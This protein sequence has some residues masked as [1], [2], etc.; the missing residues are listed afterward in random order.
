MANPEHLAILKQGVKAWNK[1]RHEN[2]EIRPDF[3]GANLNGANLGGE[4]ILLETFPDLAV[5]ELIR[6]FGVKLFDA[7]LCGTN[8]SGSN[9]LYADL[10]GACLNKANLSK[11]NLRFADLTM[12]N[13]IQA[14]LSEADLS[15]ANLSGAIIGEADLSRAVLRGAFLAGTNLF[16]S[17]LHGVNLS[18]SN[19]T[20]ANFIETDLTGADLSEAN[21]SGANLSLANLSKANLVGAELIGTSLVG[22]NLEN[23]DL[24][25]CRI[26][27]ISA[28]N[29]R[30]NQE[31]IQSNL[32]IT[33]YDEAKL[34]VDDL[35]VAQFLYL[36]LNNK[37]I[38]NVIDT[39][40]KKG[41]LILGRFTEERKAVLDAIRNKLRELGFIPLMFD[42]EKPTQRDFTET[43][44]ILAGMSRFII[45]DITNPKS[46][47]LEL[48]ATM[49]DYMIP[50]VPIIQEGEE[51]FSMFQDLTQKYGEWV[52][53]PLE[54]DTTQG[55]LDVFD[56]AV[57]EPANDKAAQLELK[58]AEEIRTRHVKDYKKG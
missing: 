14:A 53:D 31:T 6:L 40:G 13:L 44:K 48:Q 27:G 56:K 26:Y 32:I 7:Y 22:T 12:A 52:L 49:P 38:R 24:N 21:L 36:L 16:K 20:G 45:A 33:R 41:V 9:L 43:I 2:A 57:I 35:E 4:N 54:Y 19:L 37:K 23:A 50:F 3:D 10:R 1:W 25:G 8:L 29:V 5:S 30:T 58:K 11:T 17:K 51:P 34:T 55:L 46:S 15:E 28:W 39:V 42:F 18:G 47:P